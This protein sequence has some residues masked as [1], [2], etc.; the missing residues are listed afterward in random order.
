MTRNL[1][2]HLRAS[3]AL[4]LAVVLLPCFTAAQT[5]NPPPKVLTLEDALDYALQHYPAVRASMEQIAAARSGVSL[6]RTSYLPQLNSVYQASRATQNQVP[7]IW[8]PT[9]ITATVEG[10]IGPAAGQS[11]WGAQAGALFPGSHWTLAGGLP[12]WGRHGPLKIR[13]GPTWL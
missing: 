12:C 10:P 11:F 3:P 13:P 5:N 6:A 2:K 9:P 7:G 4:G 8:L 1:W